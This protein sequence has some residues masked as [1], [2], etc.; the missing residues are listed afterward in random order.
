MFFIYNIDVES[1]S[2]YISLVHP[3]LNNLEENLM[4]AV[5]RRAAI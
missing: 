5:I 1:A 2:V 3:N 4:N